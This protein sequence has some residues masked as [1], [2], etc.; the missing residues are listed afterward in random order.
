MRTLGSEE[1]VHCQPR[2]LELSRVLPG[3]S[4][5]GSQP[6]GPTPGG[7]LSRSRG[8]S[9]QVLEGTSRAA[10][11]GGSHV[12]ELHQQRRLHGGQGENIPE[13]VVKLRLKAP[14]DKDTCVEGGPSDP[15]GVRSSRPCQQVPG[16]LMD[17]LPESEE[18]STTPGPRRKASVTTGQQWKGTQP[19]APL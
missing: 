14:Q 19:P 7:P 17:L 5:R 11:A 2:A 18:V 6:R 1:A 4:P 9:P 3:T 12:H 15:G 10:P 16:V 8:H 13:K